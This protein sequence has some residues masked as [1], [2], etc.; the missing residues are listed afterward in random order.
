[1]TLCV[2]VDPGLKGAIA[3]LGDDGRLI[4]IDPMP[5]VPAGPRTREEF[6]VPAIRDLMVRWRDA[7][8]RSGLFVT[9]EK[10]SPMPASMGGASANFARGMSRAWG[11][12][13]TALDI[14]H[15]FVPPKEWQRPLFEGT[16]GKD[17]KQRSI[18]AAQRLLPGINLRRGG[19]ERPDSGYSD[20]ALLALY[21]RRIQEIRRIA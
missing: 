14:P 18:L 5:L 15:S 1:M 19:S 17:P 13:L 9:I 4:R 21:G 16:S 20:A 11:W 8:S 10:L 12:L 2:G 3:A 7:A 6:D